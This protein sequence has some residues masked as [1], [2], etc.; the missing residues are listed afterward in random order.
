MV[1]N[2]VDIGGRRRVHSWKDHCCLPRSEPSRKQYAQAV[3]MSEGWVKKWSKRLRQAAPDDETVL[4]GQSRARKHPPERLSEVVV[5]RIL[6]VRDQPPDGLGRPP[7]AK[8]LLY[9]LPRDADLLA[10]GQRLPR[11]SRTI[12]RILR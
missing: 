7:G 9:Y 12:S 2:I 5:E 4:Q 8:A 1:T 10:Q 6:E 11:S 3:G